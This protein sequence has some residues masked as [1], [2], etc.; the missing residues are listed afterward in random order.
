ML[1]DTRRRF[2]IPTRLISRWGAGM[3]V[4]HFAGERGIRKGPSYNA[5]IGW[6]GR[7]T[8]AVYSLLDGAVLDSRDW[9]KRDFPQ[10]WEAWPGQEEPEQ[11]L[12]DYMKIQIV[13]GP[14]ALWKAIAA[15]VHG[16]D[17]QE[18]QAM[19]IRQ[20]DNIAAMMKKMHADGWTP[21]FGAIMQGKIKELDMYIAARVR[22]HE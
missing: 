12:E 19:R 5:Y 16:E 9:H 11:T 15:H 14:S 20:V 10:L 7:Q 22:E 3:H 13:K 2:S 18:T 1:K 8:V 21:E 4:H 6:R 17:I